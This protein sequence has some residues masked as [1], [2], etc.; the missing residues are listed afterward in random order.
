MAVN[1]NN[2]LGKRL[3][4]LNGSALILLTAQLFTQ[5]DQIVDLSYSY[6]VPGQFKFHVMR[7]LNKPID[8]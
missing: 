8:G 1:A 3:H 6:F 7:R 5:G 4:I 2:N